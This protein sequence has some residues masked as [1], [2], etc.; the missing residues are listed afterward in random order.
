MAKTAKTESGILGAVH[1]T[2]VGLHNAGVID[3]ATMREFDA[4]CLTPVLPMAP[5]EIKALREREQVSQPVFASYLNVRKDAVSKWERG[6]KRPD[7]PSLKL[8]NLVRAKGL[9]AIA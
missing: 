1:K 3:K 5:E 9:S 6:E 8:L 2:A 7:G 4:L